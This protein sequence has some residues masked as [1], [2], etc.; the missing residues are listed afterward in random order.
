MAN[1]YFSTDHLI[2]V[3]LLSL[4]AGHEN[5]KLACVVGNRTIGPNQRLHLLRALRAD[6]RGQRLVLRPS[7]RHAAVAAVLLM[8]AGAAVLVA[9]GAAEGEQELAQQ[10]PQRAAQLLASR[11]RQNLQA[12]Q[13][14]VVIQ[15]VRAATQQTIDSGEW[16]PKVRLSTCAPT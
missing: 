1:A 10:I 11:A 8:A 16:D 4:C 13:D 9:L 12:K 5:L 3:A 14:L 15:G 7:L 6:P 2:K